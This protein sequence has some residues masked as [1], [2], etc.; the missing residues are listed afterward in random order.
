MLLTIFSGLY[1]LISGAKPEVP[2]YNGEVYD[3]VGLMTVVLVLVLAVIFYIL[4]GRFKPIFHRGVHWMIT[5]GILMWA[6]FALALMISQDV[7]GEID[8]YMYFFSLMNAVFACLLFFICSLAFK[9][10]SIFAKRTPF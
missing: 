7:I 4:L 8:S 5:L 10:A 2:E 9:R 1:E 3:S 6:S